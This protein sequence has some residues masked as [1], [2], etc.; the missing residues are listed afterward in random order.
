M[1]SIDKDSLIS[2]LKKLIECRTIAGRND[3]KE[4]GAQIL[5]SEFKND[6]VVK[7]LSFEGE[8]VLIFSNGKFN[9][10]DILIAC[11]LDVVDGDDGMFVPRDA[12]GKVFGR[13]SLDMKGSLVASFFSVREYARQG[14]E[15]KVMIVVTLDEE[16]S[17]ASS[18]WLNENGLVSANFAILPDGGNDEAKIVLKQ[19]GFWQIKVTLKG[20]SAHAS[21]PWEG[22]N[23]I[24]KGFDLCCF[25]NS[26]YPNPKNENE[27]KTSVCIT[28]LEAGKSINQIPETAMLYFDIRYVNEEDKEKIEKLIT[29]SLNGDVVIEEIAK[30]GI[31]ITDE[32]NAYVKILKQSIEKVYGV[33]A[34]F[35]V[36]SGTSD[37]IFYSTN[38]IPATLFQPRGGGL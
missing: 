34:V 2:L 31:F 36:E 35:A 26:F 12:D 16:T 22:K 3:E 17:G 37:A 1:K 11:H 5:L 15:K 27:W 25:L 9:Y 29:E 6:F 21:K 19:K 38:G 33:P 4:R 32:S 10:A 24:N 20:K 30:N 28:R 18:K 13:G 23:P 14:G 7:R 8:P